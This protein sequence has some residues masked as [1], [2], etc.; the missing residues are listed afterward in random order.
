MPGTEFSISPNSHSFWEYSFEEGSQIVSKKGPKKVNFHSE[1]ISNFHLFSGKSIVYLSPAQRESLPASLKTNHAFMSFLKACSFMVSTDHLPNEFPPEEKAQHEYNIVKA[2]KKLKTSAEEG[3]AP[4]QLLYGVFIQTGKAGMNEGPLA[5]Q[6]FEKAAKKKFP[7]AQFHLGRCYLLGRMVDQ[8]KERAIDFFKDA[9]VGGYAAAQF[10]LGRYYEEGVNV[11][12]NWN[13]AK[14]WYEKAKK[15]NYPEAAAKLNN[16]LAKMKAQPESLPGKALSPSIPPKQIKA[17]PAQNHPQIQPPS[18][19]PQPQAAETPVFQSQL[20]ASPLPTPQNPPISFAL[21][22]VFAPYL[23]QI[24]NIQDLM[25]KNILLVQ[26]LLLANANGASLLDQLIKA[27]VE[28]KQLLDLNYQLLENYDK[29][30]AEHNK[31]Y[32]VT[33]LENRAEAVPAIADDALEIEKGSELKRPLPEKPDA[34]RVR[35]SN[36]LND[37]EE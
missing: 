22:P 25:A 8:D 23:L 11:E 17:C 21:Q 32:S 10:L 35:I 31:G 33:H 19:L 26:E 28:N 20:Q 2:I 24:P 37:D 36:L 5:I 16:L 7:P 13:I 3:Y 6:W 29:L 14:Y 15:Q 27:Q 9:A 18:S 4:S 1:D 34:K 12:M 30:I